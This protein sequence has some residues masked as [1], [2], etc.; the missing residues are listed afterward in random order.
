MLFE[1]VLKP[2]EVR[3]LADGLGDWASAVVKKANARKAP[4]KTGRLCTDSIKLST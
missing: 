3:S 1:G 2:N 4:T